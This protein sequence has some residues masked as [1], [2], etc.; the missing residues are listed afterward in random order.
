MEVL[1]QEL[2]VSRFVAVLLGIFG[3]LS[4]FLAALGIYGVLSQTVT[5]RSREIGLRAA[6]GAQ[7]GNTVRLFVGQGLRLTLLGVGAGLVASLWLTRFVRGMLYGV[8]PHDT[9]TLVGTALVLVAVALLAAWLPT[10][11]AL[12]VDPVVALKAD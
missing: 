6:L 2:V 7:R 10:R 12:R 3:A 5:A 1:G 4:L 8:A 11:R 9:I